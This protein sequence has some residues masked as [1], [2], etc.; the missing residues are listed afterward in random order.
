MN[1]RLSSAKKIIEKKFGEFSVKYDFIEEKGETEQTILFC[2][3]RHGFGIFSDK[4][5]GE[6]IYF[7]LIKET[8]REED[9]IYAPVTLLEF[10]KVMCGVMSKDILIA[11][12]I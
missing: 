1:Q 6:N 3:T 9:N 4:N 10:I 5:Q 7:I 8:D 12:A 11:R 2:H